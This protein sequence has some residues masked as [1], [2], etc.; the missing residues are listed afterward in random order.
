MTA[1]RS[2]LSRFLV[3]C[4]Q[5][6]LPPFPLSE[7]TLC[8]FV[9]FLFNEHLSV[10]SVRLY[11]SAL[12]FYQ[13]SQGG[14]NPSLSSMAQ[15]HYVLRGV[16]RVQ[17][18][19][20]R[21]T[22]L[23]ITVDILQ[24]LF[25]VWAAAS[26]CY[27]ATMLWAACTLGFFAFLRSGEFTVVPGRSGALLSP[28]DVRVDC[29]HNPTYLAITLRG[30]KTDPV[31]VGCTLYI[32]RTSSTVCPVTALL[33]YLSIRPPSPGPLFLHSDGSPLTRPS[34]V[35]A[36][37]AALS[38]TGL[39]LSR[40]TGHSFRVGAATSAARAGLPDSLIQT[41]GRWRSPAFLRYIR[42]PTDTLLSVSQA[43][44]HSRS[45]WAPASP[46]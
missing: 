8:R 5:R 46:D 1:Y 19:S 16:S 27:E 11:L 12:R 42:T 38:G 45:T 23:P 4:R 28:A 29:H 22:R 6:N 15:L 34:L 13:I 2:G 18:R 43:L 32:G 41:L 24:R 9:A 3:F 33:A 20:S 39:D 14:T 37:R 44:V 17:P 26:P 35:S 21:P 25:Q 7:P 10:G 30:S 31:G 36:V 40:Y